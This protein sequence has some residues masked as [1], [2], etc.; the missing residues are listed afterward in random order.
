MTKNNVKIVVNGA[1]ASAQACVN[2]FKSSGAKAK[3]IIMCDR[4]GIIYK[5]RNNI[6]QFKSQHAV[7]TK[8]RTLE[9]AFKNADVFLGLSQAG[10]LKK[11]MIKKITYETKASI[12]KENA[13][14]KTLNAKIDQNIASIKIA[15][16]IEESPLSGA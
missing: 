12:E 4:K 8:L 6:D 7:D 15:L 14:N 3:N 10:V 11:D 1:G 2:L 13:Y 5:G 9:E 16:K